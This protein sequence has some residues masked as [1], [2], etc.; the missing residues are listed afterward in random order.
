RKR[1]SGFPLVVEARSIFRGK[2]PIHEGTEVTLSVEFVASGVVIGFQFKPPSSPQ[3][4]WGAETIRWEEFMPGLTLQ[5]F[6][7]SS[8]RHPLEIFSFLPPGDG[9]LHDPWSSR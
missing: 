2:R 4:M 6:D 1:F 7:D 8:Y 3:E 9:V 5:E